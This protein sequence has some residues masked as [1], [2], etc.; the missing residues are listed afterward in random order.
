M[1]NSDNGNN[2]NNN[3]NS[4]SSSCGSGGNGSTL[5]LRGFHEQDAPA[6]CSATVAPPKLHSTQT[7]ENGCRPQEDSYLR[8]PGT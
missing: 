5:L 4:N 3:D 7:S 8:V 6:L 1:K 2:N